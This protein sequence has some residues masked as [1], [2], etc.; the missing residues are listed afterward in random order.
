MFGLLDVIKGTVLRDN[1]FL[2]VREKRNESKF[3]DDLTEFILRRE[4][5]CGIVYSVFPSDVSKMEWKQNE[6]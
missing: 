2:D 5:E 3:Y 6:M 4:G 1:I